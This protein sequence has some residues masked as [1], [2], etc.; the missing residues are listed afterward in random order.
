MIC[1]TFPVKWKPGALWVL[2]F[3][4]LAFAQEKKPQPLAR[5]LRFADRSYVELAGTK[6]V[7]DLNGTYTIEAWLRWDADYTG[8]HYLMGDEAWPG[9][10]RDVP[11][12][13]ASGWVLRTTAVQDLD[14]RSL[15]FSVAT[16]SGKPEWAIMTTPLRKD[17]DSKAWQHIAICKTASTISLFW[18]GKLAAKEN[19]QGV[20]FN[21]CPTNLFLGVRKSGHDGV[22]FKGDFKAFRITKKALYQGEFK[23][24]ESFPS[25]Q[26]ALVLLDFR[27][28][29]ENKIGDLTGNKHEGTIVGAKWID[30]AAD[31]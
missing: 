15:E 23:P 30:P 29:E 8:V 13:K 25:D 9:M 19:C 3:T 1:R 24:K 31:K 14:K 20:R 11:V 10:S 16:A 18:N 4:C 5:Y 6:G 22:I 12:G 26:P 21:P 27:D 7:V 28:V 17:S 2:A